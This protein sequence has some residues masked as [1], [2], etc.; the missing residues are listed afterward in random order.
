[1][2]HI[3]IKMKENNK[4]RGRK[5][6]GESEGV[7]AGGFGPQGKPGTRALAAAW[8]HRI[9]KVSQ[10][11]LN[12][13]PLSLN[14]ARNKGQGAGGGRKGE[15]PGQGRND[16]NTGGRERAGDRKGRG[17]GRGRRG[18]EDINT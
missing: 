14:G 16:D 18:E 9:T 6:Q 10:S 3:K 15:G 11:A 4:R 8:S 17:A 7:P 1:M 13:S 12:F 2:K 5:P